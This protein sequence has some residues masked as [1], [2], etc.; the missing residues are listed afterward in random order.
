MWNRALVDGGET[1]WKMRAAEIQ[2]TM[3]IW[4]GSTWQWP[5]FYKKNKVIDDHFKKNIFPNQGVFSLGYVIIVSGRAVVTHNGTQ[6]KPLRSADK[7][8]CR[9]IMWVAERQWRIIYTKIVERKGLR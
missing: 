5:V 2:K 4:H 6:E 7:I 3:K 1:I 9:E 8:D